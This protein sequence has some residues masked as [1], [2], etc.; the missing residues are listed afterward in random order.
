MFLWGKKG[1]FKESSLKS[2]NRGLDIPAKDLYPDLTKEPHPKSMIP[3]LWN[4]LV[5]SCA[6]T[7][8]Q[9][10]NLRGRHQPCEFQLQQPPIASVRELSKTVSNLNRSTTGSFITLSRTSIIW[11]LLSTPPD[12]YTLLVSRW[13][14]GFLLLTVLH[15]ILF[16]FSC[17]CTMMIMIWQHWDHVDLGIERQKPYTCI[18]LP[19]LYWWSSRKWNSFD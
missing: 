9:A 14:A 4:G 7:N 3:A 19:V 1:I 11:K 6:I 17:V 12:P 10:L 2:I 8:Y 15:Y 5:S 13:P 18:C 16:L